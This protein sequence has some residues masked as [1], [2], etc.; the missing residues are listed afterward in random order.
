MADLNEMVLKYESQGYALDY[1][2]ARVCQDIILRCIADGSLNRNVT[3]KGGV[4][5]RSITGNI[6]RATQ[7][8]DLDFIRYSLDD[9][10]I[11]AFIKRIN[12]LDG[13][14]IEVKGKIRKL[15]HQ[16]YDGKRVFVRISDDRGNSLESKLDLGVHKNMEIEQEEYCFDVCMDDDGASLLMNSREQIFTEKLKSL[17]KLGVFTTR[18]K[19]I[20]DLCYLSEHVEMD[21]L[22]KCMDTYIL[23]DDAMRENTMAQVINRIRKVLFSRR[24]RTNF[25]GEEAANW[26]GW[27][28]D[29][30]F[31]MLVDFLEKL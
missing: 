7:D 14:K 22:R 1:A 28:A 3:I 17:L 13:I 16:D 8:I 31:N 10:A 19:D 27:N 2:E 4:V 20:P 9:D 6:R 29:R 21:R 23:E 5:M 24:F 11:R 12:C 15:S 26:L 30:E 25:E 18:F